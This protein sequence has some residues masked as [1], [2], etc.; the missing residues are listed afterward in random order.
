MGVGIIMTMSGEGAAGGR[1]RE[2][3]GRRWVFM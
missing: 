2:G 3:F 1:D